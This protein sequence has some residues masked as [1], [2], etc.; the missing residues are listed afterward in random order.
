MNATPEIFRRSRCAMCISAGESVRVQQGSKIS[1][2]WKGIDLLAGIRA[3]QSTGFRIDLSGSL[4]QVDLA[5]IFSMAEHIEDKLDPAGHSQFLEN[6]VD[7]VPD[8][9]FLDFKLLGDF[10]ILQPV[11]DE[12]NH[13]L[14][15]PRQE[16]HFFRIF[17][18]KFFAAQSADQVFEVFVA[19]PDL[20]SNEDFTRG[21]N[22][23]ALKPVKLKTR[24]RYAAIILFGTGAI[25]RPPAGSMA[26]LLLP[27]RLRAFWRTRWIYR[28]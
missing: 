18:A 11:G 3:T 4:P 22:A 2:N 16:R 28:R 21:A 27:S 19:G 25:S 6:S 9:V 26:A 10:A 14:F 20:S 13:F 17:D 15:A 5:T 12:M 24:I 23:I 8:G 7:V 1:G